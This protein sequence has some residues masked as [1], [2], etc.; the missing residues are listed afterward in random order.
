MNRFDITAIYIEVLYPLFLVSIFINTIF[1]IDKLNT[2]S[3][4]SKELSFHKS[5]YKHPIINR[6]ERIIEEDYIIEYKSKSKGQ[7]TFCFYR[8]PFDKIP[9]HIGLISDLSYTNLYHV[10]DFQDSIS[11]DELH[12]SEQNLKNRLF[13]STGDSIS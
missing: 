11:S 8:T 9:F 2:I 4:Q 3:S 13:K 1:A 6:Y 12:F 7:P 10:Y 5:E